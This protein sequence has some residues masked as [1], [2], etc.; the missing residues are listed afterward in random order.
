MYGGTCINVGC[1]PT[2]FLVHKA[3]EARLATSAAE[4]QALYA[5]AVG[6]KN[7]LTGR[8]RSKNLQKAEGVPNVTVLTGTA[9]L[10]SAH[11]VEVRTESGSEFWRASRIS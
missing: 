1:I 8:L 10:R 9:K 6:Q 5:K 11:Q 2:K 7:G 4:R 3:Q